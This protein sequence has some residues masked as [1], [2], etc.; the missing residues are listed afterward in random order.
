MITN[1]ELEYKGNLYPNH[2]VEFTQDTDK[3]YFTTENGVVLQITI[4]R[5]SVIRFRY[6]TNYNFEPDFSYQISFLINDAGN[7][8]ELK[9]KFKFRVIDE[10][11]L[12][13]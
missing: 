3:L 6:A 7:Y 13:G 11:D 8:Y 1:T 10:N 4:L 5:G 12:P 9:D 2:I